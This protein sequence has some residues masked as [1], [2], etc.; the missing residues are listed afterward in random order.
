MSRTPLPARILIPVANP[1]TAEELIR[2]GSDL[3]EKRTGELTALGIVEVPEGMPLSEGATRARH[4]RRLLQRVLDFAPEGTTI[5]PIVRIGRHAAEGIVEASAEQE[6]DLIIFGWGGKAPSPRGQ[7]AKGASARSGDGRD[8]PNA[9]VFSPT[10]DEVVRDSPCDIAVVKQRGSRDIKR[11][12]VPVRGGPH[13][14]LAIRFADAIARRHDAQVTVLHLVPPGIT[15][16]VRAQAEH[17]LAAFIKQHVRGRGEPLLREASNVRTAILREAERSDLVVMGASASP[18]GAG[19]ESYLFGA[20]PEAIAARAK[21]SV[22]V[23]K[24]RETIGRQTFE[25]LAARAETLVAAD[26]AAE[27]ARAIPARVERWFGESNFHHAEFADVGR[28]VQLKAKQRL[29]ISLV[30]P[31]LN[32]EETIGPIV[33][34]AFREMVERAPL[35]DEIVVI[36]SVSTDRTCEIAAAEGARVVSHPD[37]LP[38]YGSFRGKGEALWKSLF[39]TTGDLIVWADTDVRNWHSRMVYGTLGPLLHEPRLQ[40]V[41]GY[42]QRPIVEGGVLKEGGGGRV[43]ELVARPLINLFYPEL[44]GMIQPLSGEYAGRRSLLES[45]PFFTGY[46]VEIGHLIDAAERLGIEGLGQVDLERRVHRNQELEGLSRMS[47]VILQAVMKRLEERRRARLF[48]ELGSTMKLPRSGR[49]RLSLEVIELADQER[50]PMIRI[51]EYLEKRRLAGI[52][53]QAEEAAVR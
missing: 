51:P 1:L 46:A 22:V 43:T 42:Y 11:V 37:I 24:T 40:Y 13:A 36:D 44:S 5:H 31:T 29:S 10:I 45:I 19:G 39:E 7:G 53:E 23:V 14:E 33:R 21:P 48:A 20:L 3:L 9:T 50:P 34:R 12:L 16:A 52:D 38:R 17:A 26:R 47:F 18:G 49:G 25:Q 32:E 4:A 28:L 41:K 27:E 8:G 15:Q 30:L 6:A 35:L 2:I